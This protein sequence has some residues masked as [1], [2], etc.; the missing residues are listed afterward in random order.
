MFS[1]RSKIGTWGMVLYGHQIDAI[2]FENSTFIGEV[3]GTKL[4]VCP[5]FDFHSSHTLQCKL[6]SFQFTPYESSIY[7]TM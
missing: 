5:T 4:W 7:Q 3:V 2:S 1:N 6:V